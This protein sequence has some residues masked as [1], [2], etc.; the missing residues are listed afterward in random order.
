MKNEIVQKLDGIV[1]A[2]DELVPSDSQGWGAVVDQLGELPDTFPEYPDLFNAMVTLCRQVFSGL[3]RG[4]SDNALQVID[5]A[6][7]TLTEGMKVLKEP[8]QGASK[9][10]AALQ[11]LGVLAPGDD[12]P[13]ASPPESAEE[14]TAADGSR[15]TPVLDEPGGERLLND[16]AA[17]LVQAEPGDSQA[18]ERIQDLCQRIGQAENIPEL[19]R[20][21]IVDG[22]QQVAA[23]CAGAEADSGPLEALGEQVEDALDLLAGGPMALTPA[24]PKPPAEPP[25][26]QS[27]ADNSVE[28]SAADLAAALA[29]RDT[30]DTEETPVNDAAPAKDPAPD[31]PDTRDHMPDDADEELLVEFVT[32][33][34]ELIADAEEA[35]LT[36]ETDPDDSEAI[37]KVFRAFHTV[38]GTAA[39]LELNLVS[40]IGH[41]AESLLSRVRDQEIRYSGGY[42]DL[43]LR[44]LDMIKD[45]VKAVQAALEGDALLK[46]RG[47][48][49]LMEI[50]KDPE[51]AGV[52]EDEET[53]HKEAPRIGDLLVAQGKVPREDLEETLAAAPGKPVGVALVQ[54]DKAGLT[55]VSQALRTQKTMKGPKRKIEA[56]VRVST[57]RLDRLIDS[58]GEMVIAYSMIAQDDVVNRADNHELLKKVSHT[59]KIVRELQDLSMSMRM[60]PLKSTFKKMARLVRDLSRKVGKNV[61]LVTE[62]EDTEIDR[63]LVDVIN[64]PLV[65]MIRNSVDH[66]VETPE[67]RRAAGKAETGTVRLS[68]YHSAGAVVVEI[69]DDGKGLNRDV[70]LAKAT[71]REL[72]SDERT[73]SDREIY[74]LIFE[75]GFSTAA[76]VTDVSG[77]G[78]GMDVVRRN[79]ESLRGQVDIH[80][81]PGQG[82]VFKMSLPLTLAIIDGMIIRV[83]QERYII[84]TISIVRSLEADPEDITTVFDKGEML[85]V[86]E[87]LIPLFR[88]GDLFHIEG[89]ETKNGRKLVVV[90]EEESTRAGL[91]IDEL[92]GRQQVVIK[93]LGETMSNV[94]GISGGAIMPNGRVGLIVD[95]GQLVR[96]ANATNGERQAALGGADE[97]VRN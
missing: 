89:Q 7:K 72:I 44:A 18:L 68:A 26:E 83:G 24:A 23:G 75:P 43:A 6:G 74:N 34:L 22:G 29:S 13:E 71:E 62:G 46:P 47:Y 64:D 33:S 65:H 54:A 41:H 28:L 87:G 63:N 82:T 3:A 91:V 17:L 40:E 48:D 60:I 59:G 9:L 12:E 90:V 42:A 11:L 36:L 84:P 69:E 52:D 49:D 96:L 85:T 39:F 30:A 95:V 27:P 70:I 5:A 80:S 53:T 2:I 31:V 8:E 19:V 77:R 10:D 93:S 73:L 92:I 81:T 50:L 25:E 86:S 38:K 4:R 57:G 56:S 14:T 1:D 16:L 21:E 55:D 79:I 20:R 67:E 78:V 97:S 51:A 35:L 88:L 37:D 76:Q 15:G 45:L 61:N 32:E 58:V 66:G 94:A